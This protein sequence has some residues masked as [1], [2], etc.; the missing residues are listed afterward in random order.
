MVRRVA[1]GWICL[2]GL[3]LL[4]GIGS[5]VTVAD[6]LPRHT[7]IYGGDLF[8]A[9]RLNFALLSQTDGERRRVLAE[10][11]GFLRGADVA[12]V[13]LEG[14]VTTGGYYYRMGNCSYAYRAFPSVLD[15]LKDAGIDLVTIGNNHN[16]DYGPEAQVET[17]DHLTAAGIGYVGAGVD[18]EDASRPVYRQVGDVVIAIVNM[19]TS[20]AR[21][22][23]AQKDRPGVHFLHRGCENPEND[24]RVVDHLAKIVREA[25]RHAHVV[26]F[27]PHGANWSADPYVTPPRRAL[28]AK[29]IREAGFDA[30]LGHGAHR[31]EG[32]E[33]IDGKPVIYDAGN[34]VLDFDPVQK[35]YLEWQARGML[36]Q[37]E[38]SKAGVH[39]LEGIPLYMSFLQTRLA[40]GGKRDELLAHVVKY[41]KEFGTPLRVEQGRI[42]IDA[43]PGGVVE[44]T[45]GAE[46]IERPGR[47]AIRRAPADVLHERL[48]PGATP[49]D[50]RYE[51]G[52]RLVGY[53]MLS[54]VL[55]CREKQM[56]QV[57]LLYWRTDRPVKENCVVQ[58][59]ARPLDGGRL[60][61]DVVIREEPHLPGDWLFP[62][63]MWPVG[64]IIQDAQ[65]FRMDFRDRPLSDGMAFFAGL[66]RYEGDR[67]GEFL[68]PVEASG[69]KLFRG[70]RVPLGSRPIAENAER[71]RTVYTKWQAGRRMEL[72]PQQPFGAPPLKW[73]PEY[74]GD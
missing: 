59:E 3:V 5:T 71:P 72:C 40:T 47:T 55:R 46:V 45:E 41:S 14:M 13:N 9:R 64:K 63:Y 66:R 1:R 34:F 11:A 25:R 36:W 17:V 56:S 6:A 39:R 32:V 74:G 58:L 16:G 35:P 51:N 52:I 49:L 73:P 68:T 30:V 48:P 50:V 54:P 24:Q 22:Y 37:V 57:V 43:S 23:K 27:S 8:C 61:G 31:A 15:L 12:M 38:F 2:V 67:E 21:S 7:L 4:G 53:E 42:H 28:A 20:D 60:R 70:N 18:W 26:I 65:N 33:I 69:V 29:L 19:E 10:V 62:T 44:P